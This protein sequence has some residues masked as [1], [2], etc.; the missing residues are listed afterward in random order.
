[1]LAISIDDTSRF[2]RPKYAREQIS[3]SR[4]ASMDINKR[5]LA[6]KGAA[7]KTKKVKYQQC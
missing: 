4:M 5:K 2:I 6:L 3:I 7:S 1:M